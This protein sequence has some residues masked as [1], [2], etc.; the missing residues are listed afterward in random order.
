VIDIKI[1]VKPGTKVGSTCI[2]YGRQVR[3]D[4]STADALVSK[5]LAVYVADGKREAK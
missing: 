4:D 5:G 2:E 3:T 1:V